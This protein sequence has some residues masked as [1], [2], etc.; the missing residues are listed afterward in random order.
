MSEKSQ[1]INKLRNDR[2]LREAYVRSKVST[3]IASQIRALRRRE[4]MT[5][6]EFAEV[7]DMKQSR[8]SAIERPGTKLAIET[9]V[10]VAAA[11]KIGLTVRFE[12]YSGMLKWENAF[13]QDEF[14]VLNLDKDAEFANPSINFLMENEAAGQE[15]FGFLMNESVTHKPGPTKMASTRHEEEPFA[16]QADGPLQ[17]QAACTGR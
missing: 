12:S 9:L 2:N 16:N 8:I 5:Q 15:S 13:N 17:T 1:L 14:E 4:G 6:A 7:S 3:N 10:R 11:L